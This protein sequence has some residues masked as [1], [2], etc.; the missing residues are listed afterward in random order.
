MIYFELKKLLSSVDSIRNFDDLPIPLRIITTD[1]NTGQAV[2]MKEGDLAKVITASVAIPT[3]FEPVEID[4]RLYVDGLVSRNFP[5]IDVINMGADIIIG[6]DVGNEVKD[7]KDYNILSVLNQ[8]VAIQSASSTSE[9]RELTSILITPDVLEYSATDLD[10]GKLFIEKGE[11][12]A[13]QQISLLAK[14]ST[15]EKNIKISTTNNN[16]TFVIKNIEYKNEISEKNKFIINSILEN[17]LNREITPE[18]LENSM[19][20]VYR[21]DIINRVYYN[22]SY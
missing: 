12:A 3:L 16:K 22:L 15:R 18:D 13:R 9:Q 1:L 7:K 21:N 19:L 10:K 2:A 4:N 14:G 8:L 17:I 11:E 5:V 20:K 6:S